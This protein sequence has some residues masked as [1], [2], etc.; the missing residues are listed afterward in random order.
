MR[1]PRVSR[2]WKRVSKKSLCRTM[3]PVVRS[4]SPRCAVVV[5]RTRGY[6]VFKHVSYT[7]PCRVGPAESDRR[8]VFARRRFCLFIFFSL[9][10]PP[11][12]PTVRTDVVN[13]ARPVVITTGRSWR[14]HET[15]RFSSRDVNHKSRRTLIF[16]K[17]I[18][19]F[20]FQ[21]I[22]TLLHDT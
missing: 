12:R 1:P 22:H 8:S 9:P 13:F 3:M 16:Y 2:A 14:K 15:K 18:T 20:L 17:C 7:L 21:L 11:V 10:P 4:S 5:A 19:V 6:V